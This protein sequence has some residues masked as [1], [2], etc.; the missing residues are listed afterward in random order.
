MC[1]LHDQPPQVPLEGLKLETRAIF[2]IAQLAT[3]FRSDISQAG[4]R[5]KALTCYIA[6]KSEVKDEASSRWVLAT[7]S[8]NSSNWHPGSSPSTAI[9]HDIRTRERDGVI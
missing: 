4:Y 6:R 7:I 2:E 5:L 3:M 8:G 9:V 1:V